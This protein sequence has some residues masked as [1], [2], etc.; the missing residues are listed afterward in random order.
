MT[1]DADM[2]GSIYDKRKVLWDWEMTGFFSGKPKERR[3]DL[4][5]G[6]Y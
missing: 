5:Q 1:C 3:K 2:R 6:I 4:E